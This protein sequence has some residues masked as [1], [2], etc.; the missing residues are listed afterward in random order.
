M[1]QLPGFELENGKQVGLIDE[2]AIELTEGVEYRGTRSRDDVPEPFTRIVAAAT[3]PFP[4]SARL[5]FETSTTRIGSWLG[6]QD[7]ET[8]DEAFDETFIIKAS[9]EEQVLDLL[10]PELRAALQRAP[11]T[12]AIDYEAGLITASWWGHE[13]DRRMLDAV[14]RVVTMIGLA[15]PSEPRHRTRGPRTS[16][17]SA[18]TERRRRLREALQD[19]ES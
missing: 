14:L 18:R 10:T 5:E 6:V 9:D 12:L 11:D 3:T 1:L 8:G 16:R 17:P 4:L 19:S 13:T 15:Q 2:I 7:V